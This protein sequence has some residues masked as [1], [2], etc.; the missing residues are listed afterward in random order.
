MTISHGFRIS[1]ISLIA[2][3]VA[4][5][6]LPALATELPITS[7]HKAVKVAAVKKPAGHGPIKIASAEW[8]PG[9]REFADPLILG[10]GY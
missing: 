4:G 5:W 3:L 8:L 9:W 1:R 10:I 2:V 7:I 6:A